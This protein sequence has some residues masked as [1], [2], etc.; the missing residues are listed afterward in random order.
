MNRFSLSLFLWV[1]LLVLGFFSCSGPKVVSG[2]GEA[3]SRSALKAK[4]K[5]IEIP[6]EWLVC[7]GRVAI[8]SEEF[9][10]SG[11]FRMH[12]QKDSAVWIQ[13]TKLGFEIGRVLITQ[14]SI[15]AI[16]KIQSTYIQEPIEKMIDLYGADIRLHQVQNLIWNLPPFLSDEPKIKAAPDRFEINGEDD[17][18]FQQFFYKILPP[19]I[20]S[21]GRLN[22][23]IG[24][25][26][27]GITFSNYDFQPLTNDYLFSY[28]R[29]YKIHSPEDDME[30]EMKISK[31]LLD[32][33]RSMPIR[34]PESYTPLF[35]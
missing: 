32:E 25:E 10:G 3:L 19:F 33:P 31:V 15:L 21:E 4:L 22:S 24:Q 18:G 9:G 12:V 27:Y 23:L 16:N 7:S 26:N 13:L 34:I 35:R 29:E 20:L 30:I 1:L 28:L 2:S 6:S 8:R 17:N 5:S 11:T 14:D